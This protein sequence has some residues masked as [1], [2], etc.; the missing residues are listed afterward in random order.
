MVHL[1]ST[2]GPPRDVLAICESEYLS[3]RFYSQIAMF[4]NGVVRFSLW[5]DV[6]TRD[7]ELFLKGIVWHPDVVEIV[8]SHL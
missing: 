2:L 4:F 7:L 8:T 1:S 5:N 6:T 3:K